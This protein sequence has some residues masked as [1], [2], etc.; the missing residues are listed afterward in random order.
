MELLLNLLDIIPS[1]GNTTLLIGI[2]IILA[3]PN[4][5]KKV[6]GLN[7]EKKVLKDEIF[8][9]LETN[10]FHVFTEQTTKMVELLEKLND[11]MDKELEV[12]REN[13]YILKDL[14]DK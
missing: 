8:N 3:F 5:K 13:N 10:H 4:L 9:K 12:T 2:L 7:G 14:K 6:F 11:K 1:I